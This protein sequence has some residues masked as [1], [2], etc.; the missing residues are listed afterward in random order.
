MKGV[1]DQAFTLMLVHNPDAWG[2]DAD[3]HIQAPLT[4]SG[5]THG[6]QFRLLGWS[7]VSWKT[8]Y[9]GGWYHEDGRSLYVSTGLG[10]L[11]P[12]RFGVP[13]EVAVITLKRK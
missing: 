7:P 6:G 10:G 12:F 5:H 11:I 4:L 13:G 3:L 2:S 1:G 9:G 8:P